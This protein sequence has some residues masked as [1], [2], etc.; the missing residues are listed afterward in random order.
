MN[1]ILLVRVSTEKQS[2]DAQMKELHETALKAG[3]AEK[4]IVPVAEKESGIKLSEEERAGLNKMKELIETGDF[5]WDYWADNADN[6]WGAWCTLTGWI[7]S[8]IISTQILMDRDSTYW[9]LTRNSQIGL[10]MDDVVNQML[11]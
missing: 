3:Y 6:G 9:D 1:C 4:D 11:N 10:Y 7:Q 8:W 5:N 2:Y